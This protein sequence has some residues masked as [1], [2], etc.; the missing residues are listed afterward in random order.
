MVTQEAPA[1]AQFTLAV[2]ARQRREAAAPRRRQGSQVA[3]VQVK[4]GAR[5]A[6]RPPL[7]DRGRMAGAIPAARP[8]AQICASADRGA[9]QRLAPGE[10]CPANHECYTNE[11]CGQTVQCVAYV[12]DDTCTEVPKCDPEQWSWGACLHAGYCEMRAACGK[13]IL[14]ETPPQAGSGCNLQP[15][16]DRV[17]AAPLESCSSISINCPKG[18]IPFTDPCGCGCDQP[19]DCPDGV[20]C[21]PTGGGEIRSHLCNSDECPFTGRAN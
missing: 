19:A 6:A 18:S 7:L 10:K 14:C 17:F 11:W 4:E 9:D 8:G 15:Q 20:N 16:K 13:S 3:E 12:K 1:R 5:A 21:A 2:R